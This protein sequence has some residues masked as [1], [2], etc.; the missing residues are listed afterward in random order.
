M[1]GGDGQDQMLC[2]DGLRHC[3][4]VAGPFRDPCWNEVSPLS[5]A[6]LQMGVKGRTPMRH[7]EEDLGN[8]SLPVTFGEFN[9]AKFEAVN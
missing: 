2:G 9:R 4:L 7:G 8:Y 3:G 6:V 5:R 1:G